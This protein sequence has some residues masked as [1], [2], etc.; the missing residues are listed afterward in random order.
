MSIKVKLNGHGSSFITF[1]NLRKT[2]KSSK[3]T[4]TSMSNPSASYYITG[5][6]EEK[7]IE[8][9]NQ[10]WKDK[11]DLHFTEAHIDIS[12]ILI[13]LDFRFANEETFLNRQYSI[14]NIKSFISAYLKELM[15]Y[16]NESE[17][18]VYI[19]E[20]SKPKEDAKK[21]LIKDG[22]HIVISNIVTNLS[23]QLDIREK[24]IPKIKYLCKDIGCINEMEDIFDKAVIHKNNWLMY[25]SA[26]P[27]SEP[28]RITHH[29]TYNF[30]EGEFS[31]ME[32]K[33]N[34]E[35]PW[36]YTSILS[37]RNKFNVSAIHEDKK[38]YVTQLEYAF[39]DSNLK[40]RIINKTQQT[41]E[42]KTQSNSTAEEVEFAAQLINILDSK[43]AND[44]DLWVRVGWCLRNIHIELLPN[45]I[46]FSKKSKKFVDEQ[47]CEKA[48]KYMKESGGL[49]LPTLCMWA[50]DDSPMEYA[51]LISKSLYSLLLN[52]A[53]N[54][55]FD[56][57]KVIHRKFEREYKCASIKYKSWYEY[58]N[59]RWVKCEDAHT[60][61]MR[62]STQM[63]KEYLKIAA[64]FTNK[65]AESDDPEEQ[66]RFTNKAKIFTKI[67]TRLKD[68]TFKEKMI[69]ESSAL[70]FDE[71]FEDE[72][73]DAN[74]NLIGF[75]NGVYDLLNLEFRE[76]YS[77][78][79]ISLC[80]KIN[81]KEYD[82]NDPY[83]PEI[84]E[85]ISKVLPNEEL[86]EYVLTLMS[87][88]LDG[89]N[90]EEKFYIWTGH[91][92]N[93]KSK[94]IELLLKVLGDYACTFNVSL[95]TSKR[96]GS[97]QTNSE[98]VRSKGRRF[99][100]LQEP[101]EG[102][103]MNAG[104][105]KELSGNDKIIARGL[106]KESI[107]FKPMFKMVLTCNH[108]PQVP[109]EDGGTWR[110]IRLVEFKSHFCEHPNPENPNEFHID[111]DLAFKFDDW[112]ETFMSMLIH[113]FKKYKAY[114]IHE[115]EEVLQCT[116]NYQRNNDTIGEF[117]DSFVRPAEPDSLLYIEELFEEY[118]EWYKTENIGGKSLSKKALRE[119]MDKHLYNS[120]KNKKK[121][122]GAVCWEGYALKFSYS[123]RITNFDFN[124]D[125]DE[126]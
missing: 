122:G 68:N 38:E 105:M 123:G 115:P 120:S 61:K 26:K 23:L 86:R 12:P 25:G 55:D 2:A 112:K 58:K 116:R 35:E 70:F 51:Q 106:Y 124:E 69:K 108:L 67:A 85:F 63:N 33:I 34:T 114:G 29:L 44:Y 11:M 41:R 118:K 109:P 80:T 74:P 82:P 60:L 48:W 14:D 53:S 10:A 8:L 126:L 62:M 1:I 102:E 71:K 36:V 5:P 7:F 84:Y 65:A 27:Y 92:S 83:I 46:E 42:N 89:N 73:L 54:T 3:F 96:V 113:Y 107:E 64:D 49:G 110:R 39:Q 121:Y 16:V 56:I 13:D 72:L 101:E 50:R 18:E 45:W 125:E 21:L 30:S 15:E 98:L 117:M 37:I 76:G 81:F 17:F 4:H 47:E 57:A 66:D 52:S 19:M 88:M 75:E 6:D 100:V 79:N 91:G 99:A 77:E 111:R 78:D 32:N 103:K 24:L 20:K 87:S 93:G 59:H 104:F 43:R 90:K 31:I 40:N 22:V 97:S 94:C 95:L 9:Y 119:Y 28:Y